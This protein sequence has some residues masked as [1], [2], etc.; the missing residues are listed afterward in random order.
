MLVIFRYDRVQNKKSHSV[1]AMKT[2]KE[3]QK[4]LSWAMCMY[5]MKMQCCFVCTCV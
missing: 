1:K 3:K 5:C 4:N 2:R